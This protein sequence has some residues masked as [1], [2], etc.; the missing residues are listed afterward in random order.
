MEEEPN[1]P[2]IISRHICPT[3]NT[4][5]TFNKNDH[6]TESKAFVISNLSNILGLFLLIEQTCCLLNKH[7]IILNTPTLDESTLL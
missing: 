6:E 2:L 7:E 4:C 3:P 5:I 1:R